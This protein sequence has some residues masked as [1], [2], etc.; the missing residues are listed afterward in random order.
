M[1]Q[2]PNQPPRNRR[3]APPAKRFVRLA[4]ILATALAVT[5][6]AACIFLAWQVALKDRE[7]HDHSRKRAAATVP[8]SNATP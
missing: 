7:A 2:T 5:S 6:L 8:H 1:N 3:A 4:T